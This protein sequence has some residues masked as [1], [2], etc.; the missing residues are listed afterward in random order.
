MRVDLR[1]KNE[2]AQLQNTFNDMAARIEHEISLRKKS[3]EDRKKLILDIS[4]DL[5]NPMSSIQG[6][7]E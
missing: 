7:T 2:F 3:E 5:K 1:L 4:H 6:Y